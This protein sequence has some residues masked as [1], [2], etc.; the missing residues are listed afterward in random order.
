[1]LGYLDVSFLAVYAAGMFFSGHIGDRMNLRVFL[2]VGMLG[3]GLFTALFGFGYW[4]GIHNFYFYLI[5]Q[6]LA[7]VVQS[8]GWP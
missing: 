5:V 8:T 7:G 3:T 2:T 4:F 1:M 6:M